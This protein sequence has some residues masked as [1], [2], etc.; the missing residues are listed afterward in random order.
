MKLRA[1]FNRDHDRIIEIHNQYENE[2]PISDLSNLACSF[3]I[4]DENDKII[5][6][7]GIRSIMEA[8]IVTDKDVEIEQRRVALINMMHALKTTTKQAGYHELHAFIQDEK[9][10]RHL[11][12]HGFRNTVGRSIVINV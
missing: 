10:L 3:A 12:Q 9:W 5:T 1:V 11:I 8:V 7:G 2:C 6:A 4:A